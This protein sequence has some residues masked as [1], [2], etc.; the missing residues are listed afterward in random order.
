MSFLLI[1]AFACTSETDLSGQDAPDG[2]LTLTTPAPGAWLSAGT[3]EASGTGLHVTDVAVNGTGARRESGAT[4]RANVSL[5]RGINVVEATAL[6]ERGDELFIRNGVLAGEFASPDDAVEEAIVARVN[7]GG[8]D[9]I[10]EMASGLIVAEDLL[11]TVEAA[12]PVYADSYGVFGISAV[13][14]YADVI[15][16]SFDTP[17]LKIEPTDGSLELTASIPNFYVVINA[18]GDAVGY[19]FSENVS[20][21]ASEVVIT[22]EIEAD[23]TNG[24]IDVDLENLELE[25]K[26]FA[27][28]VELLPYDIEEYLFVETIRDYL[29][30]MLV[31]KV[32]EMVPPM[33]DETLS[34]LDPSFST[35][36]LGKE[37]GLSFSFADIDV[38]GDGVEVTLDLDMDVAADTSHTW[39]GYLWAGN[40]NPEPDDGADVSA[41]LADDLLN[42]ALFEAWRGGLLNMTLS[43]EDGSLDPLMIAPLKASQ[44]TITTDALLPPVL[45]ESGDGVEAQAGQ[46]QVTIDTPDG[47]VGTHMIVAVSLF[48][49]VDLGIEDGNVTM[50]LGDPEVVLQVIESDWGANND[51]ITRILESS[52]P[53]DT[54]L[55]L[56]AELSIPVPALY[57]VEID[58]GK[59]DRDA[60]GVHTNLEV[61]LK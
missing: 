59:V 21:E 2:T 44:A 51:A 31:E 46:L 49:G 25:F 3:F 26:D 55:S 16:L 53:I 28:D 34:G 36:I 11:A 9:K 13:E 29:S 35:E 58:D 20:L 1:A 7:E 17:E 37:V 41:A 43:T 38:D 27:Y 33:L 39:S 50:E 10:S 22:G 47:E 23:A 32:N 12:N 42:R 15:D 14:I 5:D 48:A 52:L 54:L 24:T 60:D 56:F 61:Y 4:W 57:G 30:E 40:G 19:D 8:L 18:Y 45:V 6:D